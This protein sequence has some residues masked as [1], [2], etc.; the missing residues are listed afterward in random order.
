MR[1]KKNLLRIFCISAFILQGASP[2][3]TSTLSQDNGFFVISTIKVMNYFVELDNWPT[4]LWCCILYSSIY[5]S[6]L[7]P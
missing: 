3:L 2:S 6:P 7:K 4:G 5:T 1:V